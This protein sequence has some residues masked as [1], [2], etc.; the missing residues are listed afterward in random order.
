MRQETFEVADFKTKT[1][2]WK[3]LEPSIRALN[4]QSAEPAPLAPTLGDVIQ[5]YRE[6][7]LPKLAKSTRDTQYGELRI[8]IEPK[9]GTKI[10]T[11]IHPGDVQEWIETVPL[12]Q[13]SRGNVMVVMRRLFKLAMLWGMYPVGYNPLTLVEVKGSTKRSEEPTILTPLQVTRI[14]GKLGPPYDLMVLITSSLGLRISET[15]ALRWDDFNFK[16][17]TVKVQRAYTHQEL[18]ETKS[19][20]SKAIVPVPAALLAELTEVSGNQG[21]GWVFPS[22]VTGRPYVA[23][24]L[25]RDHVQPAAKKL[26]YGKVGWHDLRHSFRSWISAKAPLTVQ[27]DLMRHA[28]G[29]TTADIYG[30]TPV[31]EMRPVVEKATKGLRAKRRSATR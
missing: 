30:R 6:Q 9:W 14:I 28:E 19:A 22:P 29:A 7:M 18:K 8:H 20:S 13:V 12:S 24:M 4:N 17:K 23:G 31:N 3:H 5:K 10:L 11:E 27:K 16:E 25:L 2:M 21:K 26:G 1:L 15:L